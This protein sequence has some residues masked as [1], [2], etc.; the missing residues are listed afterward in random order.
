[1]IRYEYVSGDAPEE[2]EAYRIGSEIHFLTDNV[3]CDKPDFIL[4]IQITPMWF[5][6]LIKQA[7]MFLGVRVAHM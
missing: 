6:T 7:T 5:L 1:M 3:Q 4:M 2:Y